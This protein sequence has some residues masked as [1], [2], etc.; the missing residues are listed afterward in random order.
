MEEGGL[1]SL[2]IAEE[3]KDPEELEY[4]KLERGDPEMIKICK[5]VQTQLEDFKVK[6]LAYYL[7]VLRKILI[8]NQIKTEKHTGH[9]SAVQSGHT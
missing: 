9:F 4:E 5:T 7:L 1:T 8:D 2:P 3:V 6:S